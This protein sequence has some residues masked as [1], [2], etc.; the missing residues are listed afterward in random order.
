MEIGGGPVKPEIDV[1]LAPKAASLPDTFLY[2]P[3]DNTFKNVKSD[4]TKKGHKH[5]ISSHFGHHHHRSHH[6]KKKHTKI[7]V[8]NTKI[9]VEDYP[10]DYLH[11]VYE[12][13][14]SEFNG[15][16]GSESEQSLAASLETSTKTLIPS[17]FVDKNDPS[18][19]T[20][21]E[22]FETLSEQN[23]HYDDLH[24]SSAY[25]NDPITDERRNEYFETGSNGEQ[26]LAASLSTSTETLIP[27]DEVIEEENY[28]ASDETSNEYYETLSEQNSHYDDLHS[29]S[30]F[31]NPISDE[32]SNDEYFETS[33]KVDEEEESS[34]VEQP[35][36]SPTSS[37]TTSSSSWSTS[38]TLSSSSSS[39]ASWV[40]APSS[41]T[42]T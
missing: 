36:E 2:N 11:N 28:D 20:G 16:L 21:K 37:S 33:S 7:P 34:E 14:P 31:E 5:K 25:E 39:S 17:E 30:A 29:S 10:E 8:E 26:S 13:I 24:S 6:K 9:N 35:E 42:T 38:E 12:E 40:T 41:T 23:S 19:E 18:D 22:Y 32:T 1:K 3:K 27:S 15:T 4:K